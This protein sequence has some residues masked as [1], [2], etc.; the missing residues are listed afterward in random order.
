MND[1]TLLF[2]RTLKKLGVPL[3]DRNG[4]GRYHDYSSSEEDDLEGLLSTRP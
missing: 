2:F 4:G 1:N 3:T